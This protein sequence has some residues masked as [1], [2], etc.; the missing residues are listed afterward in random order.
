MPGMTKT[1]T[2]K[3][4]KV[5]ISVDAHLLQVVDTYVAEVKEPGISRSSVVEHALNLWKQEMRDQFDA[6]Y[7]SSRAQALKED[8]ESWARIT[9]EAA[10]RTFKAE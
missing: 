5:T 4:E 6:V 3:K 2:A 7:Y 9:T 10:K 1:K 8:N